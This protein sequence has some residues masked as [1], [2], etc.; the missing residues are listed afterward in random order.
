MGFMGRTHALNAAHLHQH[1]GTCTLAA[2]HSTGLKT[3]DDLRYH[4]LAG[5]IDTDADWPKDCEPAIAHTYADMLGNSDVDL[6]VIATPTPTHIALASQALQTDKHVIIEKPVALREGEF[7]P[8]V[9]AA[10][11]HPHLRCVPAHV[12]RC[13]PGWT[14]I[15]ERIR[16]KRHGNVLSAAFQRMG[17]TPTWNDAFY[18]DHTRSGGAITDLHIHDVDFIISLFGTPETVHA[19]GDTSHVTCAYTFAN[20]PSHVTAEASWN[21]QPGAGFRMRFTIEFEHATAEFDLAH[22]PPLRIYKGD[23]TTDVPTSSGTGYLEMLRATIASITNDTPPPATLSDA[24]AAARIIDL[25]REQL[26]ARKET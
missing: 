21:R 19:T 2:L 8:L 13:W 11:T 23:S 22:D 26:G 15:A 17:S 16:D 14:D 5:N 12:M 18:K 4:S 7:G 9:E 25:E 20:G 1:E 3:L 10:N 6:V 24:I